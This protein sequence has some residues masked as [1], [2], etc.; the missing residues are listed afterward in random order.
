MGKPQD[1]FDEEERASFRIFKEILIK[2][3]LDIRDRE[4]SQTDAHEYCMKYSKSY[5]AK[6]QKWEN[7]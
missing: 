2:L 4:Y 5:E 7:S 6:P 3:K 1:M